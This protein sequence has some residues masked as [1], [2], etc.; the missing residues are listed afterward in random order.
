MFTIKILDHSQVKFVLTFQN[1]GTIKRILL[2]RLTE[3]TLLYT[4]ANSHEQ[5][6]LKKIIPL[7]GVLEILFKCSIKSIVHSYTI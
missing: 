4:S 1:G 5:Q 2:N 7:N 6:P 3:Q